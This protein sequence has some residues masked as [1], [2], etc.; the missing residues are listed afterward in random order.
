MASDDIDKAADDEPVADGEEVLVGDGAAAAARPRRKKLMIVGAAAA[1]VLFGGTG[2][3]LLMSG[4]G[5][6]ETE[7]AA[8]EGGEDDVLNQPVDV[9]PLLV[10]LRSPD[11]APH[12]LKVHVMLVPGPRSSAEALKN[13]VPVLLDAYQPFLRELRPEDLAGSAA[14]F[15][16]KEQLLVRARET[17]GDGQVKDVLVQDLIQQ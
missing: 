14:V 9:P 11:N 15:R 5:E 6:A 10:N 2:A 17:L 1:L 8:H 7:V 16:I 13:K 3:A 4:S 12:F